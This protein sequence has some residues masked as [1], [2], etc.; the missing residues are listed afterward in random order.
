MMDCH[1]FLNNDCPAKFI[2]FNMY[3]EHLEKDHDMDLLGIEMLNKKFN[4]KS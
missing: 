2:N 4:S 3:R 1:L